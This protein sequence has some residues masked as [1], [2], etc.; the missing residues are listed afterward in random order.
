[1]QSSKNQNLTYLWKNEEFKKVYDYADS[2]QEGRII[3]QGRLSINKKVYSKFF[4]T[5]REAA[6]HVDKILLQ[7]Q[8]EPVNVL[9][10]KEGI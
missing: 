3:Y 6:I 9:K 10:R 8:K 7:H 1:M 2:D 5:A 4:D